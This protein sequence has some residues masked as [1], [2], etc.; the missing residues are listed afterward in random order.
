[1]FSG[2][3]TLPDNVYAPLEAQFASFSHLQEAG[4]F[5]GGLGMIQ[6][7]RYSDTPVG[8]YVFWTMAIP[9]QPFTDAVTSGRELR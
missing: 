3:E 6:I 1:M 4:R 7:V 5:R 2:G 8:Q 9:A